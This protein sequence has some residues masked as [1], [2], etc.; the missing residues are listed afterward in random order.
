MPLG[1]HDHSY[2]ADEQGRSC[3]NCI[4]FPVSMSN[5]PCSRCTCNKGN[6]RHSMWQQNPD[7]PLEVPVN[8]D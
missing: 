3:R 5:P 6:P 7:I 2:D 8:T 1:E 4:S